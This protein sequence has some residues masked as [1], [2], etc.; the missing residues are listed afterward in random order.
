MS[1]RRGCSSPRPA[2]SRPGDRAAAP[3]RTARARRRGPSAQA[4]CRPGSRCSSPRPAR[5]RPGD[6]A[7]APPR[8][9][10]VRRRGPSAR[11]RCRPG[12]GCSSPRPARRRPGDRAAAP[13]RSTRARRRG[14]SARRASTPARRRR[15]ARGSSIDLDTSGPL[16]R[17]AA[18][19]PNP[20]SRWNSAKRDRGFDDR[21]WLGPLQPQQQHVL[22][23]GRL[24]GQ[25][26]NGF[27]A[28]FATALR[29]ELLRQPRVVVDRARQV[30]G[31]GRM[32]SGH[33]LADR[34]E[35]AQASRFVERQRDLPQGPRRGVAKARQE[36]FE[37]AA[38]DAV[39]Q[40]ARAATAGV[41]PGRSCADP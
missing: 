35:R 37:I 27:G 24:C 31:R 17:G 15:A 29:A 7:A 16:G 28:A 23:V 30:L 34:R 9:A 25:P 32:V 6:R 8:S 20:E 1:P 22:D 41:A 10:R 39:G 26:G 2:R 13:P 19:V 4:R 14:P 5:R 38:R 18:A 36:R 33:V 11:A 21:P 3:P 40:N 12:S